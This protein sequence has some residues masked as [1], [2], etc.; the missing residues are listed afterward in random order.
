MDFTKFVSMLHDCALFFTRAD[1][2]E[3][4]WEGVLST[5]ALDLWRNEFGEA[6][7]GVPLHKEM[8]EHMYINCWHLSR[9]ESA[10]MW[11]MY[12]KSDEGIAVQTTPKRFRESVKDV[13]E[14]QNFPV[15]IGRVHYLDYEREH[16]PSANIFVQTAELFIA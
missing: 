7:D 3:D 4:R 12:L 9:Y 11:R 8:R 14:S 1:H 10:A 5:P 13:E 15:F 6:M 16:T 2:F